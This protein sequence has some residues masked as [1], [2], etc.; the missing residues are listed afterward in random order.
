MDPD[1]VQQASSAF[2]Q[3]GDFPHQ[4][5]PRLEMPGPPDWP[6][7]PRAV[8]SEMPEPYERVVLELD[9]A[10]K[11][12]KFP[13]PRRII[14][15]ALRRIGLDTFADGVAKKNFI[16]LEGPLT[17]A[18]QQWITLNWPANDGASVPFICRTQFGFSLDSGENRVFCLIDN[19]LFRARSIRSNLSLIGAR[20]SDLKQ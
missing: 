19:Q 10:P 13:D 1:I 2:T 18:P 16:F 11:F 6:R 20:M 17:V 12:S 5:L 4:T 9:R 3:E 8:G 14:S 7:L 15:S